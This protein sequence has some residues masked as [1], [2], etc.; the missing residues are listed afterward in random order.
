MLF[1]EEK[2]EFLVTIL[3]FSRLRRPIGTAGR[4][5]H[6][7]SIIFNRK[8]YHFGKKYQNFRTPSA[9]VITCPIKKFDI[10]WSH[11]FPMYNPLAS[12]CI[13][14]TL[15]SILKIDF[16]NIDFFVSEAQPKLIEMTPETVE[17]EISENS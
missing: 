6:T 14:G 2:V 5:F 1:F 4:Y 15:L 11:M 3:N 7:N 8:V 12:N 13:C 9:R 10:H 17:I 16:I